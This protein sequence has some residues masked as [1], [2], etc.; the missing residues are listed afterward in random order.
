MAK[1]KYQTSRKEYKCSVCGETILKGLE[2]IKVWNYYNTYQVH[3]DCYRK[4]PKSRWET[5]AYKG[6]LL[7]MHDNWD[8][9]H[10][11]YDILA[12]VEDLLSE[13]EDKYESMPEQLAS[14]SLVEER[15]DAVEEA[16][17]ELLTV[18]E[19]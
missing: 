18:E 17:Q 14:G 3:T 12:N 2:Y 19:E 15:K 8:K 7:D 11:I 6:A 1:I 16:M 9:Y 10:D 4:T 5:S 13:L